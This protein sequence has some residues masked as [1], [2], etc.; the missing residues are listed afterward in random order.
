M[1][2]YFEE[3]KKEN[4][5]IIAIDDD[6]LVSVQMSKESMVK[7]I[8]VFDLFIT[9]KIDHK[10]IIQITEFKRTFELDLS[11]KFDGDEFTL[12]G[13]VVDGNFYHEFDLETCDLKT[14]ND[15]KELV[16]S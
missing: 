2:I 13:S 3:F 4:D 16:N 12:Q 9:R 15:I 8:D 7:I 14:W 6:G 5:F 1:E 10:E 11:L